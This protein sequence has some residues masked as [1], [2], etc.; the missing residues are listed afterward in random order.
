M[1]YITGRKLVRGLIR[2]AASG[3]RT[4][5]QHCLLRKL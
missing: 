4:M 2:S 5:I 3:F 1:A